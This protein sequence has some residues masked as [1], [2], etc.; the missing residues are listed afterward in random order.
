MMAQANIDGAHVTGWEA[1]HSVCAA[2]FGFPEFYGRNMDAWIDC[3]TYLYD[4]D[5]MSRF[6]LEPG[7]LLRIGVVN[8]AR[9]RRQAPE[10]LDA[11]VDCTAFVNQ[12]YLATGQAPPLH[13]VLCADAAQ[14]LVA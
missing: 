7:E 14:P 11:L 6:T 4:G 13:L 12:R 5:G 2:E 3:L 8:A 9:W 10:T 1:F